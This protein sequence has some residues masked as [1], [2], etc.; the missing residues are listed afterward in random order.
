M[1]RQ[2]GGIPAGDVLAAA[3][4]PVVAGG[5]R[6][7]PAVAVEGHRGD[8]VAAG[9]REVLGALVRGQVPDVDVAVGAARGQ[10]V[11]A[12]RAERAG[13]DGVDLGEPGP[14]GIGL[15]VALPC[16]VES[17][18]FGLVISGVKRKKEREVEG[19]EGKG[20]GKSMLAVRLEKQEYILSF[21]LVHAD[22]AA[23]AL[24]APDGPATAIDSRSDEAR[25]VGE[26]GGHGAIDRCGVAAQIDLMHVEV[27]GGDGQ[28]GAGRVHRVDSLAALESAERLRGVAQV[29]VP[30]GRI[31][32]ARRKDRRGRG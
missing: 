32:R 25:L 11:L 27:G 21:I 1:Q 10:D 16:E 20:K 3:L 2:L 14:Y 22:S 5:V 29:P 7:Q 23:P 15:P 13:V 31:P 9:A 24:D 8:G 12:L 6:E 28:E 18:G 26:L 17:P 19:R 30:N 4:G